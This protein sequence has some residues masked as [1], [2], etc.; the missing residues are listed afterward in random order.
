MGIDNGGLI[1]L[2]KLRPRQNSR[3]LLDLSGFEKKPGVDFAVTSELSSDAHQ[4]KKMQPK[5][6]KAIS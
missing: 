2:F 4:N 3:G 6:E 5:N 1:T